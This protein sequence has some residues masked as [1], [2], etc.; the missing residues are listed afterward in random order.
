M[1]LSVRSAAEPEVVYL[2]VGYGDL[3]LVSLPAAERGTVLELTPARGFDVGSGPGKRVQMTY[4][5]GSVG[6]IV[7]ARGRPLA[8]HG[9]LE[10]QRE[11]VGNWLYQMTGE[12]GT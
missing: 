7:D 4:P 2:E 8:L 1:V 11:R 10:N 5:E 3:G 6:L 12:R 9:T